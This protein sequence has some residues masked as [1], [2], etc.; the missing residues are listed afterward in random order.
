V[1]L[2]IIIFKNI[3][4]ENVFYYDGG[5][6]ICLKKKIQNAKTKSNLGSSITQWVELYNYDKTVFTSIIFTTSE[7]VVYCHVYDR[8]VRCNKNFQITPCKYYTK[9][10]LKCLKKK[11]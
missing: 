7:L 1:Y 2:H 6:L 3:I 4:Y 11:Y 10:H 8:Q 5:C 9:F